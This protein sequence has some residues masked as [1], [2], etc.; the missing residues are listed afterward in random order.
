MLEPWRWKLAASEN[1]RSQK[2]RWA[3]DWITIN[4]N[5]W[6]GGIDSLNRKWKKCFT[7]KL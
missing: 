3:F 4:K 1:A 6:I 2:I 7:R 5:K